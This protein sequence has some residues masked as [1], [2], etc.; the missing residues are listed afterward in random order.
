MKNFARLATV[1]ALSCFAMDSASAR[2]VADLANSRARALIA[3]LKANPPKR[4][5]ITA[6]PILNFTLSPSVALQGQKLSAYIQSD[7]NFFGRDLSVDVKVNGAAKGTVQT[8]SR[9]L[10]VLPLGLQT[11]ARTSTIEATLY[12]EN[13]QNNT[14]IRNAVK[15]LDV[16]I[17]RLTT[18]INSERDATKRKIL[19]SQRAEKLALKNELLTQLKKFRYK[20]GTQNYSYRVQADNSSPTLPKVS[21]IAPSS[22]DVR[23]GTK[24]VFSGSNFTPDFT[25]S[26]GGAASPSVTYVNETTVFAYT[27]DMGLQTGAKDVELRFN[28]GGSFSNVFIP[29]GYFATNVVPP[30]PQKPVAIASGSQRIRLGET[31][32][33]DGSQSYANRQTT[34]DY[35]WKVVSAPNS[36]NYTPGQVL[37]STQTITVSPSALGS[38]VFSLV[39]TEHDT[40]EHLVSDPSIVQVYVGN[41]PQPEAA[42][43]V[44]RR[45]GAGTSQVVAN[46]PDLGGARL[47]AIHQAPAKGT[48][49][50]SSSGLVSYQ[51]TMTDVGEF[52]MVVRVTNQSGL[53]GD[54]TIPVSVVEYTTAPLPTA[55]SILTNTEPGTSQITPNSAD[56][57]LTHTYQVVVQPQHGGA[58]VNSSGLV[59]YTSVS[60]YTGGDSL[61][62]KV[63]NSAEPPAFGLVE[64]GVTVN[65]NA[66]PQ[67]SAPDIFLTPGTS[68]TSQ[69]VATN[70]IKQTGVYSVTSPA[71][72]AASVNPAGLVAY[73]PGETFS[74]SDSFAVEYADNGN[75][76]LT[77]SATIHVHENFQHTASAPAIN[78]AP[79]QAGTS[80][81]SVQDTNVGQS[82]SYA[83]TTPASHG[84]A[85]VSSTGLVSYTPDTGYSGSDSIVVTVSDQGFPVLTANA[86]VAITVTSNQPPVIPE[87][88]GMNSLGFTIRS[89]GV[90]Y[91]TTM[92]LGFGATETIND[93]DGAIVSAVWNFG[94]G[95]S[96]KTVDFTL[97]SITHN[98]V[99]AGT[100]TATLTVTDNE[101]ATASRNLQVVVVDTDIPTAKFTVSPSNGGGGA[102]PITITFDASA[103]AD[104]DGITQYRWRFGGNATSEVVTTNP[105]ITR[106][107]NNAGTN[108]PIRLRTRDSNRA[109]G[110][111]TVN[112]TVGSTTPGVQ[113][114]AQF[115]PGPPRQVTVGTAMAF[116]G[117]RSFN[118]NVGGT[119]IAYNWNFGDFATCPGANGGCTG[120]GLTTS[121]TYPGVGHFSPSL[122]VQSVNGSFSQFNFQEVFI[123]NEGHAPRAI[124][125]AAAAGSP[126]TVN[127]SG[128]ESYDYDGAISNYVWFFGDGSTPVCDPTC[129]N[130][131]ENV[132][133]TFPAAN[134]YVVRLNVYDDDSN[135]T[136][137]SFTVSVNAFG[138]VINPKRSVPYDPDREYQRQLL[139]GACFDGSGEAC[140]GLADMYAEDGDEYTATNLRAKACQ[141]GYSPACTRQ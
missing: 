74:G 89:R 3:R 102:V 111:S 103:S 45:G 79:N 135:V 51:A 118:P 16:D 12:L 78:V 28:E 98:Y 90:P 43:I 82:Y 140:S 113:V 23:G 119:L 17:K 123:V 77:G 22:G 107:F 20:V 84:E 57:E 27:P 9:G 115:Q 80:Q 132:M 36:S 14:D 21:A 126:L 128:S 56:P 7:N 72:G 76:S 99:A 121:Y 1:L 61:V 33:I 105:V 129:D 24:V 41:A 26:F 120:T 53:Y 62:V 137:T 63:T 138:K 127:F 104:T 6:A 136:S 67:V 70:E 125:T 58:T 139:A 52:P 40:E 38:Y 73:V 18:S 19:E 112:V 100:Y 88:G 81:V 96:E 2:T 130:V 117:S 93:P 46:D 91:M 109:Q 133:H 66:A 48:A 35:L 31:A 10:F 4:P 92:G 116:D 110:E 71:Q 34:L 95:T 8:P 85:S 32:D 39:V 50:V 87:S 60:G 54:V 83:I 30:P 131:G 75:P 37:G 101:G 124:G 49:S 5:Q 65:A 68:G 59:T 13:T 108:I 15:A 141:L 97:G 44:V 55:P 106:T 47:Y 134:S 94:D 11:E 25:V 114:Q 122:R 86:S 64:I 69:A 29:G 42:A